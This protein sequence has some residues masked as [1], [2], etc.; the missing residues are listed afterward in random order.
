MCQFLGSEKETE[1]K[2]KPYKTREFPQG[3]LGR[4]SRVILW[5]LLCVRRDE[6]QSNAWTLGKL[7]AKLCRH[8]LVASSLLSKITHSLNTVLVSFPDTGAKHSGKSH[9]GEKGLVLGH[10]SR[11]QSITEERESTDGM[12]PL[13]TQPPQSRGTK[14]GCRPLHTA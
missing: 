12:G 7:V 5:E 3:P 14:D 11:I 2:S 4:D 1:D 13:V 9:V 8:T 6:N 10:G